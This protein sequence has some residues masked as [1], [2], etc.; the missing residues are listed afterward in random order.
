MLI[1][2]LSIFRNINVSDQ[3]GFTSTQCITRDSGEAN[4][5]YYEIYW[6]YQEDPPY[7]KESSVRKDC[8]PYLP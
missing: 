5:T 8:W 1:G 4:F 6:E 2:V 7:V 3:V